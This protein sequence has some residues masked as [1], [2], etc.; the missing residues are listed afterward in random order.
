MAHGRANRPETPGGEIAN[1]G[2]Q[3]SVALDQ[4]L[5]KR[6]QH[7]AAAAR[8]TAHRARDR[9][10]ECLFEAVE[11]VACSPVTHPDVARSV[12]E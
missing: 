2:L 6:R 10:V 12:R 3:T 9:N 1:L 8:S 4:C 5:A 11:K 7:H